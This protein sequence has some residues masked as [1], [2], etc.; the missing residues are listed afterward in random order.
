MSSSWCDFC[1]FMINHRKMCDTRDVFASTFRHLSVVCVFKGSRP[2]SDKLSALKSALS[3]LFLA[4]LESVNN[5]PMVYS[6]FSERSK[7]L[8]RR[9]H[10][11]FSQHEFA[12]KELVIEHFYD[13][14]FYTSRVIFLKQFSI[15]FIPFS[16]VYVGQQP[17]ETYTQY[18]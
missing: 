14:R 11:Y 3:C 2:W 7:T 13:L 4:F 1:H 8:R 16:S 12:L 9:D 18:R 17:T 10:L 5:I 15:L 6:N